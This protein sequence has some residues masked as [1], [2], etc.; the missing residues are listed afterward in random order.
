VRCV[1]RVLVCWW[2]DVLFVV[3]WLV[4]VGV[5]WGV[6]LVNRAWE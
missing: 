3:L 2:C 6:E 1:V 4:G 5:G